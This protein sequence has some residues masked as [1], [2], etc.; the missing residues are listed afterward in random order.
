MF[1]L[2]STN[3]P[4]SIPLISTHQQLEH[5]YSSDSKNEHWQALT[6]EGFHP[7]KLVSGCVST[8]RS[9]SRRWG[10][11]EAKVVL[12]FL[13]LMGGSVKPPQKIMLG[14]DWNRISAWCLLGRDYS[15]L[16]LVNGELLVT[17]W[18]W[19]EPWNFMTF[20][21]Q[22]GMSSQLTNTLHHF[23]EGLAKNHQP[24]GD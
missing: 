2:I 11:I 10:W 7:R 22:L 19:L 21:K 17:G 3:I 18:W 12:Q 5:S 16:I 4:T 20:Q 6:Q 9:W 13:W 24:D 8:F 14:A 15:W 1:S 23:S